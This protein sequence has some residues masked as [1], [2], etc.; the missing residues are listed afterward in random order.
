MDA[1]L[2]VSTVALNALFRYPGERFQPYL[3]VGGGIFF[4]E[5]ATDLPGRPLAQNWIPGLNVLGGVRGFVTDSIALF[6]EY[7]FN[8]AKFNLRTK[9]FNLPYG[10]EGT[11]STNIIAGGVSYHFK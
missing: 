4:A 10:F 5:I 9:I 8:Y 3:G 6:F 1:K 11:Y 7:K 2:E